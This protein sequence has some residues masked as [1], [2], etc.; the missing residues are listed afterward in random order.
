LHIVNGDGKG[1]A[2]ARNIAANYSTGN[3][4]LFIDSDCVVSSHF[5]EGYQNTLDGSVGY[6]GNVLSLGTD[7]LS[8]YYDSQKI[9]V[10]PE[11]ENGRPQ[12]LVTANTLV[13]K[14]A[15]SE[16]G[17]FDNRFHIAGGE[18]IDLAFRLGQLGTLSY[19]SGATVFHDFSDG[20]IGFVKRFIRY[21]KGNRYLENLYAID[22]SP[23]KFDP[24]K[25]SKFN[26][27]AARAQYFS[28]ALGY[29]IEKRISA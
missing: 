1:P 17:G 13:W 20:W 5:L 27:F 26:I 9:L 29:E 18:D 23:K 7:H 21:G 8:K 12:Y 10:P 6:A 16:I 25:Y 4:L 24:V 15:F 14:T 2:S 19:A 28:M 11:N 22:R 3:W